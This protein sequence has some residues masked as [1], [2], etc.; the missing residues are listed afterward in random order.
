MYITL[1]LLSARLNVSP[2][3]QR[4]FSRRLKKTTYL[5]NSTSVMSE[6]MMTMGVDL[7]ESPFADTFHWSLRRISAEQQP[8]A[9]NF[10]V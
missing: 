2:R 3:S 6:V 9:I 10:V 8:P 1:V 5:G 7:P 4:D